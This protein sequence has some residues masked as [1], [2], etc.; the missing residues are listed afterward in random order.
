M[1]R[2]PLGNTVPPLTQLP[3]E[4]GP[5]KTLYIQGI[6]GGLNSLTELRFDFD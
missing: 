2:I 5:S 3:R 1:D 4:H 6:G